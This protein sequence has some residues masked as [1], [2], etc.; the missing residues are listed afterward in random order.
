VLYRCEEVSEDCSKEPRF[1]CVKCNK[2]FA[3]KSYIKEHMKIHTGTVI[4]MERRENCVSLELIEWENRILLRA[5]VNPL[6]LVTH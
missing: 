1:A 5:M 2:T 4:A 3:Q 6:E